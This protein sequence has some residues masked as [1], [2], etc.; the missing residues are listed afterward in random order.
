MR[1]FVLATSDEAAPPPPPAFSTDEGSVFWNAALEVYD[2]VVD[3][4]L[5]EKEI[6]A[7]WADDPGVTSTPPG[8]WVNIVSL[9][10]VE[11]DLPLAV[12]AEAYAR[13]GLAVG[14]AFIACWQVKYAHNLIRPVSYIQLYVDDQ[15]VPLVGTPPFPS[16]ASG[17][18]T[19]SGAAAVV[20]TDLLGVRSF[21]D[22]THAPRGMSPRFFDAFG[23]AAQEAADSR[24]YAGIHYRFD[25]DEGLSHGQRI[26]QL[27][28]DRVDFRN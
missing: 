2:A 7:F 15:W 4:T 13:V 3:G 17:H 19:S 1:T 28:V 27:I 24:L 10:A 25:N 14:D 21:T 20:L 23:D 12:A 18:S 16:Y 11:D 8:H 26:G 22:W 6:G 9:L 5:E